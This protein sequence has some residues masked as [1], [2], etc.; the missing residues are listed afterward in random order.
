[1]FFT[2]KQYYN[3]IN[4]PEAI[5]DFLAHDSIQRVTGI[6][7]RS[8]R[9]VSLYAVK[10]YMSMCKKAIVE[11]NSA[12][13][14]FSVV[15]KWHRPYNIIPEYRNYT[16]PHNEFAIGVEVEYGFRSL[17]CAK[18]I[19]NLISRW[20]YISIDR[21]GGTYPL[22]VSF[23]PIPASKFNGK[24]QAARYIKLLAAHD[25]L[26]YKH[27]PGS[28]VGTHFN[29]SYGGSTSNLDS[30]IIVIVN[31][32]RR[33]N[34]SCNIKYFNRVPYGFVYKRISL[35]SYWLE[36][37]LFNSTT[38]IN[39]FM[40]YKAVALQIAK[41]CYGVEAIPSSLKVLIGKLDSVVA[42]FLAKKS[43][44]MRIARAA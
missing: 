41:W 12:G 9:A 6:P 10:K 14:V 22:E 20:K 44:A 17:D 27:S 32:L 5:G 30:N 15:H 38:N 25:D 39:D 1:M 28:R 4:S 18:H 8:G 3:Y 35:G 36:M 23:L 29:V 7:C 34:V 11:R 16:P 42:P 13:P 2:T 33:L 21:E 37:K 26:V 31:Y 43:A 19:A 40:K 24:C